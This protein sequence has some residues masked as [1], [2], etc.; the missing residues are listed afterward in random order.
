M[1]GER[2]A[3]YPSAAEEYLG[4]LEVLIR[5]FRRDLGAPEVP[6]F[7]GQINPPSSGWPAAA[8]VREAQAAAESRIPGTFMITTDDLS[9][10]EDEPVHY[11]ASGLIQLGSRFSEAVVRYYSQREP[12]RRR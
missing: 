9:K 11:D 10:R 5:S 12:E 3:R 2:D 1:Q 8:L 7:L 4:N 6:F